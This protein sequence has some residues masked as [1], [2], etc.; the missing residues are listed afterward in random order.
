MWSVRGGYTGEA[1]AYIREKQKR[2]K[3]LYAIVVLILALVESLLIAFMLGA[4]DTTLWLVLFFG[5]FVGMLAIGGLILFL[6]YRKEPK[7][8]ININ[9]DGFEV[10]AY[11]KWCPLAFYKIQEITE[12]DDFI[13]IENISRFK[14]ALQKDLLVEGDWEE[15]KVLLKKVEDSLETDDPLYQIEEPITEY[16]EATVKSKRI[17]ERFVNGVSW[18]TPVGVFE[19]FA[20]FQLENEEEVEYEIGQEFYEKIEEGQ[21]GTLVVTNGNFFAFGEGE[22][23]DE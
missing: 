12:Y 10:Y 4:G 1:K 9:N 8:A 5:G 18:T 2:E 6:V 14:V 17:H 7:C 20:T 13:A 16:W 11:G 23:V 21:T 19:Y 22:E 15:L 3:V